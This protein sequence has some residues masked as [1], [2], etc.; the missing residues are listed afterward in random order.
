MK[1]KLKIAALLFP[2]F[3]AVLAVPVAIYSHDYTVAQA[4]QGNE[5]AAR[6]NGNT[7]EEI[8]FTVNNLKK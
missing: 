1:T 8:C 3:I 7:I 6:A 4:V 2:F 5:D